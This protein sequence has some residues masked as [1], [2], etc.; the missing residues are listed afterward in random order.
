VVDQWLTREMQFLDTGQPLV[1]HNSWI[2]NDMQGSEKFIA[3]WRARV[4]PRKRLLVDQRPR[5]YLQL[6]NQCP[7]IL[8]PSLVVNQWS[9]S[10]QPVVNQW[11]TSGQPPKTGF[12]NR[13][14]GEQG[15]RYCQ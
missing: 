7:R 8:L 3:A 11:S 2:Q 12:R 15:T 9:A 10:G 5:I 1:E 14:V 6:V 4:A 13:V